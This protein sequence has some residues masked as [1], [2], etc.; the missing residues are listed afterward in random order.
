[1]DCCSRVS[2]WWWIKVTL[3]LSLMTQGILVLGLGWGSAAFFHPQ[4]W[5]PLWLGQ[6]VVL[7]GAFFCAAHYG[8]LKSRAGDL[9][10][11]ETLV[12]RGG[13]FPWIRHPM[14]L[15]DFTVIV[16]LALFCPSGFSAGAVLL[17]AFALFRL[18]RLEDR[19]MA[20]RFLEPYSEWSRSTR[21]LIP[22]LL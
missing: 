4:F 19:Q 5:A 20:E 21:M 2:V 1:M 16:G 3:S 15:G 13:A 17:A 6:G 8:I 10:R 18:A 14:Y 9:S 12:T 22:F 7:F 11:P